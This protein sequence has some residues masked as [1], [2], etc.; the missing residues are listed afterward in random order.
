MGLA[1]LLVGAF[2]LGALP[3]AYWLVRVT[4]GVDIRTVGSGN[5]GATNAARLFGAK[6]RLLAFL[7]IFSLDAGKGYLASAVLPG[8]FDLEPWAPA[9]AAAVAVLGHSFSPFLRFRGGKGVAT[10]IG[11][12]F[13]LAPLATTAAMGAFFL[14]YA[15][16]RTVSLGSICFA[17]ALPAA[18]WLL[19]ESDRSVFWLSA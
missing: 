12:L 13:G 14:V 16:V 11:A 9:L 3:F 1:A 17:I 8:F 15:A 18:V 5:P 4:H 19:D 7:V 6:K 2:L 10:T